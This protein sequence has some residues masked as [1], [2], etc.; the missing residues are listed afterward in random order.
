M[1]LRLKNRIGH[2]ILFFF[3]FCAS[4]TSPHTHGALRRVSSWS[5]TSAF[6]M[7]L[8]CKHALHHCMKGRCLA[9]SARA[10]GERA[11]N[12]RSMHV[13]KSSLGAGAAGA[14]CID[15][16]EES[17]TIQVMR[18]SDFIID[19]QAIVITTKSDCLTGSF[20]ITSLDV[21]SSLS[22]FQSPVVEAVNTKSV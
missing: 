9:G 19:Y 16:S 10:G 18:C 21:G 3:A 5:W 6:G 11:F 1:L 20:E 22:S 13:L 12:L 7:S 8:K 15:R 4:F 2:Q 14:F 17:E